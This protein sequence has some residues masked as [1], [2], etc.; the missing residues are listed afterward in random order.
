MI[1]V[2]SNKP[3][4]TDFGRMSQCQLDCGLQNMGRA[5]RASTKT[6]AAQTIHTVGLNVN[7]SGTCKMLLQCINLGNEVI[8]CVCYV[9][10]ILAALIHD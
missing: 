2:I 6:N 10:Q 7:E 4:L 3:N 1:H 8:L 5:S 9:D